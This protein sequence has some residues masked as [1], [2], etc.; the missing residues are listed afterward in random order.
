MMEKLELKLA[1]PRN[2]W[3]S[4]TNCSCCACSSGFIFLGVGVKPSC[5]KITQK[6]L[7]LGLSKTHRVGLKESTISQVL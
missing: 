3:T 7:I 2:E 5:E 1:R 6:K 4:A